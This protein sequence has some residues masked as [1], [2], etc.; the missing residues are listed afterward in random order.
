MTFVGFHLTF[1]VQHILGLEGMPRRVADYLDD[2]GFTGLNRISTIGAFLLGASTLPFL[3]NVVRTLRA[4]CGAVAGDDPWGGQTLEWA[5]SSPPPPEQL[6]RPAAADPV[7]PAA[8]G[9]PPRPAAGA[10]AV[11]ASGERAVPG[12]EGPGGHE[13]R[14]PVDDRSVP[15]RV[16]LAI[17]A[18]LLVIGIIYWLASYEWAG[19]VLLVLSAVLAAWVAGFLWLGQRHAGTA[20]VDATRA[21]GEVRAADG[22]AA[23]GTGLDSAHE[24]YLPHASVWPFAIG[25]GAAT[26]ANGLVWGCG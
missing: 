5:T 8:V 24:H 26:L 6:R 15:W 2:D 25:L 23:G 22:V 11:T 10:E 21:A 12:T 9:P 17:G 18:A 4:R 13:A 3:W 1:F 20:P 7:V 14:P 19:V 16:F